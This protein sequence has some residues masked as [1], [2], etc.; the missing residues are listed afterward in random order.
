MIIRRN[1]G[2]IVQ[3]RQWL[4]SLF[5]LLFIGC[6]EPPPT[7]DPARAI[8]ESLSLGPSGC[9]GCLCDD[10]TWSC[11]E[12]VCLDRAGGVLELT[13]EAGFFELPDRTVTWGGLSAE[14]PRHRVWYSFQ[15]ARAQAG[16]DAPLFVIFNG[17]PYS[18]TLFLLGGNTGERTLLTPDGMGTAENS[19]SWTQLGH[20][21]YIDAPWTGFSYSIPGQGGSMSRDDSPEIDASE[22]VLV[23]LRFLEKHAI[24]AH[25]SV[26]LMGESYG[27]VRATLMRRHV[28]RMDASG[29][30]REFDDPLLTANLDSF[31]D[32]FHCGHSR[33]VQER[34]FSRMVL[35]QPIVVGTRQVIGDGDPGR[36]SP[37]FDLLDCSEPWGYG[38]DVRTSFVARMG[39]VSSLNALFGVAVL[40]VDWLWPGARVGAY[41]R[42][43]TGTDPLSA[44]LGPLGLGDAYYLPRHQPGTALYGGDWASPDGML[45]AFLEVAGRSDLFITY[46]RLDGTLLTEPAFLA[47]EF[48]QSPLVDDVVAEFTNPAGAARPGQLRILFEDGSQRTIRTPTYERSGHVVTLKMSAELLEDVT[49]WYAALE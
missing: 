13:P 29:D 22:F 34:L 33:G 23:V 40:S 43:P 31:A 47:R 44:I 42:A 27:G 39:D 10:P 18:A 41:N 2:L 19:D 21:L 4:F 32:R 1:T 14:V 7:C 45:P 16:E 28:L 48:E 36:C 3:R 25:H 26:V 20:L 5:A 9:C 49:R 30:S 37:E 38:H 24:L 15:P 12:N 35:I 17:G 11:S 6:A 46:A 8:E